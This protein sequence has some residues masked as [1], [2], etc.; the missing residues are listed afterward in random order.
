MDDY[1]KYDAV[2]LA[3]LIQSKQVSAEEVLEAAIEKVEA[4]NPQLNAVVCKMYDEA[5][6]TINAGLP[7]GPLKGVPFLLKDLGALYKGIPTTNGSQLFTNDVADHDSEIVSSYKAAGLVILGK[8]NTPEFGLTVTTESRLFGPCHNPWNLDRTTGGSSGGAAAAVASGMV[9]VAHASDGGGSIRIPASCCGLFG[10]K[11]TRGRVP[12]AP[13]KGESW[14]GM[15]CQ[16]VVSRS[17]R[18]SALF[19]DVARGPALGDPYWAP[20]LSAPYVDEIVQDPGQLKIA[21]TI[22]PPSGNEVD[23]EC[24]AATHNAAK[25]CESLGHRVE[26]S[27]PQFDTELFSNSVATIINICIATD[28]QNRLSGLGRE[29]TEADLET[30][31]SIVARR[32]SSLSGTDYVKAVQGMHAIGRQVAPFFQSHDIL[33]SP[34]LLKPPIPLG[35][36]DM[37]T[38]K[39]QEYGSNLGSFFGFTNLF[40]A[41]GQPSMSV[42]LHWTADGLP[43]GLQFTASFG[44]EALLF[45]LAAQL[46]QAQPWREKRPDIS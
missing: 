5:W 8:T 43:V 27:G 33:L 39:P 4:L 2:D 34:V 31:T 29:L 9:P 13:D 23:L 44:N 3:Q 24:I 19:L 30:I 10:M 6:E 37:T 32:G 18:D 14:S 22:V 41:T 42:P 40:N 15:S 38:D 45:R 36:L 25:L 7:E 35:I 11:P 21:F 20:P 17:V 26:E 46:E 28:V 1:D 16:H 12:L